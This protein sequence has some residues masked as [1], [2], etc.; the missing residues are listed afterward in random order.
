MS[1]A[2]LTVP[3]KLSEITLGQYQKF[4]KIFK[5][6]TDQD[7]LQ[8]KMIEIFC[9]IPLAE[10]NKFK[11]SSI[12]KVV[13]ILS[14]MFNQ[15]PDLKELF[16][17]DGVEYGFIPK[18]DDMTFGEFVDLDTYSG[19]WQEMDKAMSVLFRPIKEK[20]RGRYLIKEYSGDLEPMKQMP[21]DVA[22]G[23]I[24]FLLNLNDQLMKHTLAYSKEELKNTT[25]QQLQTSTLNGDGI[26]AC[27]NSLEQIQQNL[28]T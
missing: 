1:K 8:K 19:D 2:E 9:N 4:S 13:K 11:Y 25:I 16:E 12:N 7:F 6:D 26:Q 23:A 27:I 15:K 10:V 20:F 3:N 28:K 5:E 24:F 17:M 22:L 21:L 18:L 14:D